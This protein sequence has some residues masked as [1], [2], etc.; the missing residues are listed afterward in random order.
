MIELKRIIPE[1]NA[2][3]MLAELILQ[4]GKPRHCKGISKVLRDL[5]KDYAT[6]FVIGIIDTDKFKRENLYPY[7]Q[8][9]KVIEDKMKPEGL[10]ILNIPET[11]KYIVRLN[12]GFERWIWRLSTECNLNPA[13]SEYGFN[14]IEDLKSAAKQN[15]LVENENLKKF[16]NKIVSL[17][18]PPIQTLRKWLE[19]VFVNNSN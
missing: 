13:D 19:K 1:C 8:K 17:N 10:L 6:N 5:E 18:P 16:V 2:D 9:F 3:S 14:S 12:P 4:R 15:E 11:N 7:L